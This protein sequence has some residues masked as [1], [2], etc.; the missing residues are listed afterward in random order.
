MG[1]SI[2]KSLRR[3]QLLRKVF[4]IGMVISSFISS[5]ASANNQTQDEL[6]LQ[7]YYLNQV[8]Q[9]VSITSFNRLINSALNPSRPQEISLVAMTIE[10]MILKNP[11]CFV[12]ASVKLGKTKCELIEDIFIRE[13]HFNP[14]DN[15]KDSLATARQFRQSCFA[16]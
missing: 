12:E 5:I 9:C 11:N 1:V 16:S 7:K 13:P 14:R 8:N 10:E 4:T 3:I 15:L 2:A 6:I